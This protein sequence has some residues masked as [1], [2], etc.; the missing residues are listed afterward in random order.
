MKLSVRRADLLDHVYGQL[1]AFFPD[2]MRIRKSELAASFGRSLDRAEFCFSHINAKY[3]TQGKTVQFNHLHADQ[4]A[5]FLYLLSNTLYKDGADRNLCAKVFQLNRCL[6]GL[7]AFYEVGLPDIFLLVHPLG[8]VL[9]RATYQNYFMVYQQCNVGS[10]DDVYPSF[11][12]YVC[13]HPGASVL[14]NCHVGKNSRIA[15]GSLLLDNDLKSNSL[16]IGNPRSY[17]I[18]TRTKLPDIW[19][20]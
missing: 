18:Q 17:T 14:G 9:G 4:Y 19:R 20:K 16:Y 8:T 12:E 13:L 7:D 15:A 11:Q 1:K 5:M 6:H 3:F 2:R 10:N